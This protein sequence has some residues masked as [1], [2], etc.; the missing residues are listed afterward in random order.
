MC[1]GPRRHRSSIGMECLRERHGGQC[2]FQL[3]ER[4]RRLQVNGDGLGR[5]QVEVVVRDFDIGVAEGQ[6]HVPGKLRGLQ[7]DGI[8]VASFAEGGFNPGRDRQFQVVGYVE[9]YEVA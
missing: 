7:R 3:L 2:G 9:E 4:C 5:K 1:A 8:V 6:I